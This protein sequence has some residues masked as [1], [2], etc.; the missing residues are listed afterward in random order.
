MQGT[1]RTSILLKLLLDAYSL[2]RKVGRFN[3]KKIAIVGDV[4]HSRVAL[5]NIFILRALGAD[6]KLCAPKSLLPKYIESLGVKVSDDL[7]Q[8]LKWCDAVNMLRIQNERTD[9]NF[10]L[11]LE[12][13]QDFMV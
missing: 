11:L 4:L 5:S 1:E 8:T 3:G 6:I 7:I 9:I 2:I 10:F 13:I 12:N